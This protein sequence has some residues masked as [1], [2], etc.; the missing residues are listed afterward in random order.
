M[1]PMLIP[2]CNPLASYQRRK[3]D[4][5]AAISTVLAQGRYILGDQVAAFEREFSEY[6]GGGHAVGVA[7]GTDGLEMA[8]RALGVGSG[9]KVYTVSHT[10]VATVA[11]IEKA[12]AMPVL[13]DIDPG[14]YTM[15]PQSLAA[16][17]AAH[18]CGER[19]VVVVVHLYGQPAV[20]WQAIVDLACSHGLR[21][22]ED[23]AQAHGAEWCGRK[24]GALGDAA[25]FS[26]Y[27]TKN[28]GAIG[29]GGVCFMRDGDLAAKLRSLRE[30][31]WK[32]RYVSEVPGGNSRLDELQAA[33][34]RV[35]LKHLDAD[36]DARRRIASLYRAGI[37][38]PRILLPAEHEDGR[39]V[40]HQFVVRSTDRDGLREYLRGRNI[41]TLIHYPVPIHRQPAYEGRLPLPVPGLPETEEAASTIVSLPMFPELEDREIER[42]V[43]ALNDWA[44]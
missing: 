16:A 18:P 37:R 43:A 35:K 12:G 19:D 23:C 31:G 4:I 7:S 41:G 24:V 1:E 29:D 11:A 14:S 36:N 26:L 13:V 15:C 21:V 17:L 5:D 6:L 38:N 34:L 10:A 22:V 30:Y 3:A 42:V 28:L 9:A 27:P 25:A 20:H 2:Q 44:F 39:H 32:E 40:Y 8:L 33:I